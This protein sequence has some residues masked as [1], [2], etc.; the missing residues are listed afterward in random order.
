VRLALTTGEAH[1]NRVVLTL[2][3]RGSQFGSFNYGPGADLN[4]FPGAKA[5]PLASPSP[6]ESRGRS[7]NRPAR[8]ELIRQTPRIVRRRT[9][10]V[11]CGFLSPSGADEA[12]MGKSAARCAHS[13]NVSANQDLTRLGLFAI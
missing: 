1:N 7:D 9:T 5:R 4:T 12:A 6:A 10:Q 13:G 8:L 11:G 2:L 3:I